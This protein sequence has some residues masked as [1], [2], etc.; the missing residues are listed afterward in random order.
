MFGKSKRKLE[1][2]RVERAESQN[3]ERD[4]Q[5][6][7]LLQSSLDAVDRNLA[8]KREVREK[9]ARFIGSLRPALKVVPR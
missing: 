9:A 4:A 8:V 1:A 7:Q 5:A 6:T 3:T 2:E